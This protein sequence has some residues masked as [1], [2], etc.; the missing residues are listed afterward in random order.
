MKIY[1]DD[2]RTTPE[3]YIRTFTVEETI[4]LIKENNGSIEAVSLDNDLGIGFREGRE[5]MKW[6]E[7][8]AFHNT[9]LPIPYL[10]IHSGNPVAEDEMML[11]RF[12]AWKFWTNHGYSH[13]EWLD[14][15]YE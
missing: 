9:L 11:A 10:F 3:G 5:V 6:I 4:A 1:L 8:Q 12:N 2:I 14:K 13:D 7:E 15:N